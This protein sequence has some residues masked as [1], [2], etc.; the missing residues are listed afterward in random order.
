M[1]YD[2]TIIDGEMFYKTTP[3]GGWIR[4]TNAML[5]ARLEKVQAEASEAHEVLAQVRE[6]IKKYG[7]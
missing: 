3:D 2:E 5:T 1:Y 6:L 4:A 7:G